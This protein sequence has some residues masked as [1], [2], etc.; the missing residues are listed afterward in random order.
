MYSHS[1]QNHSWKCPSLWG[2]NFM[3]WMQYIWEKLGSG[4]IY[5]LEWGR[6]QWAWLHDSL[7]SANLGGTLS[8]KWGPQPL[9]IRGKECLYSALLRTVLIISYVSTLCV[10]TGE[11]I[12]GSKE[13][14]QNIFNS[15]PQTPLSQ[16][17]HP[18]PPEHRGGDRLWGF[19]VQVSSMVLD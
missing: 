7:D 11:K 15:V 1:N 17:P 8:L 18:T 19:G 3:P 4:Y 16:C 6:P 14:E 10:I 12:E 2:H 9:N 5:P 13:K